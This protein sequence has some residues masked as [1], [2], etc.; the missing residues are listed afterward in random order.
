MNNAEFSKAIQYFLE[1]TK[2]TF[3]KVEGV[4]SYLAYYNIGVIYEVLR[5]NDEAIKYYRLSSNYRPAKESLNRLQ[6]IN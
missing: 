3:S 5:F 2:Y 1:C 4:T 6:F